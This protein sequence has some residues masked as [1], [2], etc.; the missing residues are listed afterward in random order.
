M[1]IPALRIIFGLLLT[2]F[3]PGFALTLALF[4]KNTSK[5]ERIALGSVLSIALTLL[6]ALTLDLGLG[7]DFTAEN[8]SISLLALTIFF[9]T[10][11]LMQTRWLKDKTRETYNKAI[12]KWKKSH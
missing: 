8:M 1:I 2:L 5:I 10:V 12:R 4:P 9:T 6:T 7:V 3:I 11:W